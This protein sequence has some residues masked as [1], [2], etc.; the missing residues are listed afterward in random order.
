MSVID[1]VAQFS[2]NGALY[3]TQH[4]AHNALALYTA[5]VYRVRPLHITC[6]MEC[7]RCAQYNILH[8]AD[9]LYAEQHIDLAAQAIERSV[10][11][12]LEP[13]AHESPASSD[14][15]HCYQQLHIHQ[16]T[17]AHTP[18]SNCTHTIVVIPTGRHESMIL[19]KSGRM[20]SMLAYS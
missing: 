11:F 17:T 3:S 13:L 8:A 5:G 9:S 10:A 16:S 20:Y 6:Y 15:L 7:V 12:I 14:L 4:T 2:L 19:I 18:L 1:C